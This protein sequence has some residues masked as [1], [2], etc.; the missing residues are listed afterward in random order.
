MAKNESVTQSDSEI[1][2]RDIFFR[3]WKRRGIFLAL[4]AL[5][6]LAGMITI[7][8]G[9][10]SAITP[11]VYY[12]NLTAIEKGAYP[13]GAAFSPQ[14]LKGPRVINNLSERFK[15]PDKDALKNAI[16]VE[17]ANPSTKGIL[18]N[19]E[20]NLSRPGITGAEIETLNSELNAKMRATINKTL[21]FSVDH[22]SLGLSASRGADLSIMIPQ[23]WS[24]VYTS[25][26]QVLEDNLLSTSYAPQ[27]ISLN[28]TIGIIEARAAVDGAITGLEIIENDSRLAKIITPNGATPTDLKMR[29]LHLDDIYFT[30][31]MSWNLSRGDEMAREYMS[32]IRFNIMRIDEELRSFDATI[33]SMEEILTRDMSNGLQKFGFSS[34]RP[35]FTGEAIDAPDSVSNNQTLSK[36]LTEVYE[37]RQEL[38]SERASL[39]MYVNKVEFETKLGPELIKKL[40]V[41]FNAVMDDFSEILEEARSI[42]RQKAGEF[43]EPWGSPH[44]DKARFPPGAKLTLATSLILG[45]FFS[46]VLT[47]LW[48]DRRLNLDT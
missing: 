1:T 7:F 45:M 20:A 39:N 8:T 25:Q 41:D 34:G 23:V 36:Y 2:F 27:R 15:F 37:F 32:D 26:Y 42:I 13:N 6:T 44:I 19:Y 31:L 30:R 46:L 14:D 16:T 29:I 5:T 28:S 22:Q 3:I 4:P 33:K 47:L 48:P 17:Y 10:E 9:A 11:T 18:L 43:H 35:Q 12:I 40:E 21:R 24:E 38:I